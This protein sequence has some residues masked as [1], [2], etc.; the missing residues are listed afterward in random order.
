[1]STC[2]PTPRARRGDVVI[3]RLDAKVPAAGWHAMRAAFEREHTETG[4]RFLVL[5]HGSTA[6]VGA[7]ADLTTIAQHWLDHP[8]AG[9]DDERIRALCITIGATP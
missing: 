6:D 7:A 8:P 1:M 2:R 5:T 3:V 4:V 9:A